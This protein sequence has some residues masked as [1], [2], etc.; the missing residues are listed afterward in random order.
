M[1][2]FY[3]FDEIIFECGFVRAMW[4]LVAL[5]PSVD[6]HMESKVL[7]AVATTKGFT[8]D[9]AGQTHHCLQ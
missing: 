7:F 9:G 8:T 6:H 1:Y 4:T 3:M 5:F 2:I